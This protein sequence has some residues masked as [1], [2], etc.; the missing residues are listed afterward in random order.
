MS[1]L[2]Q[3]MNGYGSDKGNGSH[4]YTE[5]Y[6]KLFAHCKHDIR[7]VFELGIGT[8][9]PYLPSNMGIDGKPGASLRGFRDYFVNAEIYGADI[10]RDILFKEP[11]IQ[12]YYCD[13]RSK[14]DILTMW[15]Q[16]NT[17]FDVIIDD[18][19]HEFQANLSFLI[20]SFPFLKRGGFYIVEDIDNNNYPY[21]CEFVETYKQNYDDIYL[22]KIPNDRND[23]DNTLLIIRK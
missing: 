4:N 9:N 17:E 11:R 13:Q 3:L 1:T 18:G 23:W 5:Y 21:W 6:E 16:I 2:T 22:Y 12:T 14:D 19:L 10:D 7:A 8:N 20:H 15:N